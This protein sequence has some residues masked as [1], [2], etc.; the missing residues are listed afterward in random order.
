MMR[1][2]VAAQVRNQID[3]CDSERISTIVPRDG[4]DDVRAVLYDA[5]IIGAGIAGLY[6]ATRM[7]EKLGPRARILALEKHRRNQVGG[8]ADSELFEGVSVVSGAGIGR[9][10]KDR[11]LMDLLQQYNVPHGEFTVLKRFAKTIANPVDTGATMRFLQRAFAQDQRKWQ[12]RSFKQF[13]SA[14]LGERA[15]KDYIACAQ[16][17]D[18]EDADVYETLYLYGLE[19][20][21]P[22]WTAVTVPWHELV[23]KMTQQLEI[24][25]LRDVARVLPVAE[26]RFIVKTTDKHIY[27]CRQVVVAGTVTSLRKLFPRHKMYK[28]IEGQP[29]LRLYGKF[30]KQSADI[31]SKE[32]PNMTI[33]P[34]P[35]RN[36]I[37]MQEGVYMIAYADSDSAE[38]L[39][40]VLPNTVKNRAFLCRMIERALGIKKNSLNMTATRAYYWPV[41][42]HYYKPRQYA[43]TPYS[44]FLHMLQHPMPGVTVVGEVVAA[45][46]GWVEG[47]LESVELGLK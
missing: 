37:P 25:Y 24:Q 20:N 28:E 34:G 1:A 35:L 29:Y 47:A 31:M 2:K 18:Y 45:N 4:G 30:D 17:T 39:Q 14:V 38:T 9:K 23:R 12:G 6:A 44:E 42:T 27:T 22:G 41:G 21:E 19:D 3:D 11:L 13:A 43:D 16:H 15:Y 32:V 46:H 8:R 26:D 36:I 33:V 7:R 5:I 10:D 40:S